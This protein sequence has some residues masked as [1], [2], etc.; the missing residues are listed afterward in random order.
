MLLSGV[1]HTAE[2]ASDP[3]E[4][5]SSQMMARTVETRVPIRK[6]KEMPSQLGLST[7][8]MKPL[9]KGRINICT[10]CSHHSPPRLLSNLSKFVRSRNSSGGHPAEVNTLSP[11]NA[12][13][14][15]FLLRLGRV[16]QKGR[17]R[18]SFPEGL[19]CPL[20]CQQHTFCWQYTN[21]LI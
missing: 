1:C 20:S 2:P 7:V 11:Q 6:I 4:R 16:R 5:K 18:V 15:L 19:A 13:Q 14:T 21:P 8:Q 17:R 12:E 3:S 10:S 9:M